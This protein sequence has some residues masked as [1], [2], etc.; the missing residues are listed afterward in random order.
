M[1]AGRADEGR[2]TLT[3]FMRNYP[4]LTIG[5]VRS[6]LPWNASYLDRTSEALEEAGM[7]P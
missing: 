5:D 3:A 6:S 2:R 7:R 4:G 1:L